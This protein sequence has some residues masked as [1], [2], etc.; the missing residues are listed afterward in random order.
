MNIL[1]VEGV[2]AGL[3]KAKEANKNTN[4]YYKYDMIT[5]KENDVLANLTGNLTPN[6]LLSEMM[7]FPD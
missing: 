7:K 4:F 6:M 5:L 1:H 2:V 3:N